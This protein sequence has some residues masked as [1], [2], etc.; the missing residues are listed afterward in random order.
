MFPSSYLVINATSLFFH[1][2]RFETPA[3]KKN[4]GNQIEEWA[5]RLPPPPL[6]KQRIS[7]TASQATRSSRFVSTANVNPNPI[8]KT[9][10]PT[11][12]ATTKST[13]CA[14]VVDST[15]EVLRK[16]PAPGTK[17]RADDL[18]SAGDTDN[19]GVFSN[20]CYEGLGEDEPEDDTL[21]QAD[22]VSSPLKASVA[23]QMSKVS[24]QQISKF[25]IMLMSLHCR[26]ASKYIAVSHFL[27]KRRDPSSD[28]AISSSLVVR[29]T[30]G[31]GQPFLFQHFFFMSVSQ[32]RTSG[33]SNRRTLL[34]R[35]K[36]FGMRFTR[37][38]SWITGR[39]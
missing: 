1:N 23:A 21:E 35:S 25:P 18:E 2:R 17:R 14:I 12:V 15:T 22:A 29:L 19:E 11:T 7:A 27:S 10:V 26:R 20:P 37:E 34:Q 13:S 16:K 3:E 32:T 39:K 8:T 9:A 4:I 6:K 38:V 5:Q 30:T 28:K 33:P 24:P 31:G 36:R